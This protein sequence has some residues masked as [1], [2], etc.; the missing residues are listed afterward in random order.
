MLMS[1]TTDFIQPYIDHVLAQ[2]SRP[3]S[4]YVFAQTLG[5]TERSF[6]AQYAS[7]DALEQAVFRRYF[8]DAHQRLEGSPEFAG[9]SAREKVLGLFFTWFEILRDARSVVVF[10]DQSGDWYAPAAAYTAATKAPFKVLMKGILKSGT[11]AGE[12]A[13]RL[14][15]PGIYQD[16]LWAW[17]LFLLR[18]WLSDTSPNFERTDVAIEKGVNFIFDLIQPNSLDSGVDLLRFLWQPSSHA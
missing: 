17:A 6:Y 15:L 5:S 13:D 2:G 16:G 18:F 10:L 3:A 9:Y 7:F 1:T 4:V 12:I 8:D 11:D 14:L